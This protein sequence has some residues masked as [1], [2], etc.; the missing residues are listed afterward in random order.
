M[1]PSTVPYAASQHLTSSSNATSYSPYHTNEVSP[2]NTRDDLDDLAAQL[3]SYAMT[4]EPSMYDRPSSVPQYEHGSVQSRMGFSMT[5]PTS[6]L[7]MH[8]SDASIP[9][10][11]YDVGSL[12][13]LNHSHP[14]L[15]FQ[16][17][18]MPYYT[19][20]IQPHSILSSPSIVTPREP[21]AFPVPCVS[22]T[23]ITS[24]VPDIPRDSTQQSPTLDFS[25]GYHH[26]HISPPYP[27]DG[28]FAAPSTSPPH[29]SY[30]QPPSPE[31]APSRPRLVP[32]KRRN[33]HVP[34]PLP[35]RG[36]SSPAPTPTSSTA[37]TTPSTN[38]WKC[39]Y[40]PHVQRNRRMPDLK[41]HV[42]THTRADDDAS[43]VCCGV[44]V[45]DVLEYGVPGAS[46]REEDVYD[47]RGMFMVGGCRKT[48]SRKD[49]YV[50]HL[51]REKGKCFGDADAPYQAGNG[52]GMEER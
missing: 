3:W 48:F 45:I 38:R 24:L 33:V 44:P 10:G 17:G 20:S 31:P 21:E 7:S 26:R 19:P 42:A 34:T 11:P 13:D 51:R 32:S 12:H 18:S 40:C 16:Y 23:L 14:R 37:A 49:A 28:R 30:S 41:R 39:P 43:W 36:L 15:H 27:G 52:V 2:H 4:D 46:V 47:H 9:P 1:N 29:S 6:L 22:P 8:P 25:E 5:D 35:T 50:R